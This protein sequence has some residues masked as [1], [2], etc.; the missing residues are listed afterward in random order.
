MLLYMNFAEDR[1]STLYSGTPPNEHLS[2]ADTH[3]I[4]NEQ[5]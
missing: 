1:L 5:F 4:Y 2:T 3:D